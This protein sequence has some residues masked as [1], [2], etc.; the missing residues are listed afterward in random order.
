MN[1]ELLDSMPCAM[2]IYR[3]TENG[4]SPV[5]HNKAFWTVLGYSEKEIEEVCHRTNMK[6]LC[7][8]DREKFLAA[9]KKAMS[10]HKTAHESVRV[11]HEV[12]S[13]YIW[14][15]VAITAETNSIDT[16]FYV[17]YSDISEKKKTE[18]QISHVF[19]NI[20][21]GLAVYECGSNIKILMFTDGIPR[22]LDYTRSEYDALVQDDLMNFVF[23]PDREKLINTIHHAVRHNLDVNWTFRAI[24]KDNSLVWVNLSAYPDKLSENGYPIYNALYTSISENYKF[25]QSIIDNS[26]NSVSVF[27][28][29]TYELYYANKKVF[30]LYGIPE[31]DYSGKKCYEVFC[32][33]KDRCPCCK[34]GTD[35]KE[36]ESFTATI[37][38]TGKTFKAVQG[39]DVWMGRNVYVLF[40]NDI[41]K[42]LA[43]QKEIVDEKERYHVIIDGLGL[44]WFDYDF[45]QKTLYSNEIYK[46]YTLSNES[47]IDIMSNKANP[48]NIHPDDL[49]K[50]YEFFLDLKKG[51]ALVTLRLRTVGGPFRWVRFSGNVL[52]DS[53]G[54]IRRAIGIIEDINDVQLKNIRQFEEYA[55]I[56][57]KI[58]EKDSSLY[59]YSNLNLNSGVVTKCNGSHP[60]EVD[61]NVGTTIEKFG[62]IVSSNAVEPEVRK[63][64]KKLLSVDNLHQC[65]LDNKKIEIE[66]LRRKKDQTEH[67]VRLV[68]HFAINP[69]ANANM[70][71]A[72]L[73]DINHEKNLSQI[74]SR[75]VDDSFEALG[76][77]NIKSHLI[78]YSIIKPD[79]SVKMKSGRLHE[80][81]FKDTIEGYFPGQDISGII[82]DNSINTIIEKLKDHSEYSSAMTI[83]EKGQKK[84]K[85]W[86]YIWF[87]EKHTRIF[88]S[89]TDITSVF[90]KDEQ[91]LEQL[92]AALNQAK[93]ANQAKS[94]FLSRM[95]HDIRTPL[96]AVIGFAE[97]ALEESDLTPVVRDYLEKIQS[98][99][100]YLL[101]LINDI[102]NM[103]KIESHKLD[104]HLS[105]V[106]GPKFLKDIND[107]FSIQAQQ[108][109]INFVTDFNH[110][111][112][113]WVIMDDLRSKQIYNNILNNALKF[114]DPGTTISWSIKDEITGNNKM[115]MVSVI[116]DQGCGMSK[117]YLSKLFQPFEQEENSH[118]LTEV[119]TGLGLSIVKSLVELM[120]GTIKVE[121][122][123]GKGTV[124]TITL[125]RMLPSKD[126]IP[127]SEKKSDIEFSLSGY[128][129][130]LCEDQPL[131]RE[132]AIRILNKKGLL[133]DYAVNGKEG[134]ETFSK[135]KPGM[136][137]AILMDIRMPIMDGLTATRNI[138]ELDHPDAK[139]IPI[140]AM[141]A[142]AF[143][144]DI[145]NCLNAGM[146]GHIA[147]PFDPKKLYEIL[148]EKISAS[149][150]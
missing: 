83:E 1:Q 74:I 149:K 102:L 5:M 105:V 77:I 148:A 138:R 12:N 62:K 116:S 90:R 128:H 85:L 4:F 23:G 7:P 60:D 96:N 134:V 48:E 86:Q 121:S 63:K 99:G 65:A 40:S 34:C 84:R 46:K 136:Y 61:I 132:I 143:D 147:K 55:T 114:S 64:L 14:L 87:D 8:E 39:R 25:Q 107:V 71:F 53:D 101:G 6:N 52:H 32:G 81:C 21:G 126:Q 79:S 2:A 130:L 50:L 140:I 124:V 91:H 69:Y 98:S 89:R 115:R 28:S 125:D 118:S 45:Q 33:R 82:N 150:K 17:V 44:A 129:I 41:T 127:V 133:V 122:E 51:F 35:L 97:L 31:C 120:G 93:R 78:D 70:A 80:D 26:Q 67:W 88:F 142:N 19:N 22:M 27:D 47:I 119:G 145:Q 66:Y 37:D 24:C 94:D 141:T 42:E 13:Q 106:N 100:K 139:T 3:F 29:E 117:E 15:D 76:I 131:N 49:H 11:Y 10:E 43:R 54:S 58:S 16:L 135:S 20:N 59:D 103:S 30:E 144:D 110:A 112:T 9:F 109:G 68:I 137:D 18:R 95:S 75:L 57:E 123:L 36:G 92:T 72:L 111:Q 56:Y 113:P 104:L 146:N 73:F 38:K 108:K